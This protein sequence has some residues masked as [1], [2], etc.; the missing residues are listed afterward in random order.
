MRYKYFKFDDVFYYKRGKRLIKLN[1][2]EGDYPY[3]SSTKFNNGIDSYVSPPEYMTI[4]KNCITMANSGSVGACFYHDYE[5]VASDHV[6]VIWLKKGKLTKKISMY[7]ITILEKLSDNYFFNR[8]M[9]DRRLKKESVLLPVTIEGNIDY[10]FMENEIDSIIETVR[11]QRKNTKK[12]DIKHLDFNNWK[13]FEFDDLF[14][15]L[16][17]G[18]VQN[19][20]Q[21]NPGE[22]P[23]I[24]SSVSN[25][26]I[27][28]FYDV[29]AEFKNCLTISL[30][31]ACGYCVY[32]DY[33]FNVNSDCGV[34]VS[35]HNYNKYVGLFM[36]T[37]INKISI[38]YQYGRKL[39]KERIK[40][41]KFFLPELNGEPDWDYMESYIKS[42]QYSDFI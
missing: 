3:I 37:V 42:I 14:Y 41:E 22:C 32:H 9:S 35:K 40:K 13:Y 26:G 30:N 15:E 4:Y 21:L 36:S 27:M 5:F 25:Q 12:E 19:L 28:G 10:D 31:G 6:T 11:W 23:V 39:S 29:P 33:P 16:K 34:L 1:Q 2:V 8:E 24:S 38:N 17:R 18:S 7:L 20:K